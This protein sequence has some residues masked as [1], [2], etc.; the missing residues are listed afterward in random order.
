MITGTTQIAIT[1]LDVLNAFETI[2]LQTYE[3]KGGLTDQLP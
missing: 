2:S 3:T 1:K